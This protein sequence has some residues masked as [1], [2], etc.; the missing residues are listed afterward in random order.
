MGP[1]YPRVRPAAQPS[2]VS[3]RSSDAICPEACLLAI[4]TVL[5]V[6]GCVPAAQ[7][8]TAH[9]GGVQRTLA[10]GFNLPTSVAVDA[11]GDVF[12]ADTDNNA[13]K[14]L[15]AVNGSIP[16]SP[17]ILTL[18]SGFSGPFGVAVDASGDVFVAD[19][20][21][22]TVK[23]MVAVGGSIPPSPTILTLGGGFNQPFGVAVDASGN[24]FV[25]DNNAVKEMVAVNGSIP[26]T[27]TTLTLG[28]G[29]SAPLGVA[30][31]G[32]G[33]VFVADFGNNAVKEMVAVKGSIPASP[34]ILTLGSG[35]SLPKGV[36][37]DGSGDVF[38]ADF[39][40]YAVK[41]VGPANFGSIAVGAT[42][43]KQSFTFNFDTSGTL[44]ATPYTVLTQGAAN[45]D[46]KAGGH[47]ASLS[48]RDGPYLQR[49]RHLHRGRDLHAHPSR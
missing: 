31:D 36:A 22:N 7:A 40:N 14:E 20:N 12:V 33:N 24:V 45:L 13:V 44:A 8:Q 11:S 23:E 21:N 18:G 37:V 26:T 1:L 35:F 16:T 19:L 43:A 38:V 9:F 2:P 28:G 47:A 30:V 42:S 46:F 49:R 32:S 15:V 3:R 5:A 48:V 10:G 29:F 17:T 6:A 34:T 27:P 39:Q 4:F 41:E 25:A